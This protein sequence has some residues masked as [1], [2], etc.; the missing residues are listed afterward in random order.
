MWGKIKYGWHCQSNWQSARLNFFSVC[1]SSSP[2]LSCRLAKL[3]FHYSKSVYAMM[4]WCAPMSANCSCA[5][6]VCSRM[7]APLLGCSNQDVIVPQRSCQTVQLHFQICLSVSNTPAY[8]H[9]WHGPLLCRAMTR[10]KDQRQPMSMHPAV[11]LPLNVITEGSKVR[12]QRWWYMGSTFE[13]RKSSFSFFFLPLLRRILTLAFL[14]IASITHMK[15]FQQATLVCWAAKW[16]RLRNN[17]G[18]WM[19]DVKAAEG[20]TSLFLMHSTSSARPPCRLAGLCF[21][22]FDTND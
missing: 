13:I 7:V 16:I 21:S 18:R 9:E 8:C 3:T 17:T 4:W 6:R 11:V 22:H 12:L 14:T 10:F 5:E 20:S 15:P 2:L 19:P 1:A